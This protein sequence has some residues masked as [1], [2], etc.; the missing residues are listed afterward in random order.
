MRIHPVLALACLL[1]ACAEMESRQNQ[2]LRDFIAVEQLPVQ[3]EIRTSNRDS[4]EILNADFL[5][6]KTKKQSYLIE[7][8]SHCFDLI[9]N[10]VVPDR[11]WSS[12]TI[13]THFETINGC[14]I[15]TAYAL[16]DA[17]AE[18]L[19]GLAEHAE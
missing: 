3:D 16:S 14:A 4:R 13:R 1:L 10:R 11:R 8:R 18:E 17:Q 6:Y 15:R 5:I 9:D 7:F 12:Q 2:A 19:I